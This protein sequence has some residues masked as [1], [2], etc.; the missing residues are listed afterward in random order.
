[1]DRARRKTRATGRSVHAA[2]RVAETVIT[3]GGFSVLAAVLAICLFLLAVVW[4]LFR[5]GELR[6]AIDAPAGVGDGLVVADEY[7]LMAMAVARDGS[8]SVRTQAEGRVVLEGSLA[9]GPGLTAL[10]RSPFSERVALG[11]ADGTVRLGRIGFASDRLGPDEVPAAAASL[12]RG[13]RVI[14]PV[15]VGGGERAGVVQRNEQGDYRFVRPV[16]ELEGAAA[17]AGEGAVV[18]VDHLLFNQREYVASVRAD[19]TAAVSQVRTIVPLG[20][21]DPIVRLREFPLDLTPDDAASAGLPSWLFVL[22]AG[23][24]VAAVWEDGRVRR[25]ARD[26]ADRYTPADTLELGGTITAAATLLGDRSLL[27]GLADGRVEQWFTAPDA[28]AAHADGRRLVRGSVF[29][30]G[31]GGEVT[32]LAISRRGRSVAIGRA[33]GGVVVRHFTSGQRVAGVSVGGRVDAVAFSPRADRL[34]ALTD[35]GERLLGWDLRPGYPEVT[36]GSMFWRTHYEGEPEPT[37][38]WQS[39]AAT[40]QSEPKLSLM[41]LIFGTTKATVF[42]MLFAVP[43]AVAGAVYTS[44]FLDTRL[45]RVVKPS[46][47]IMASLPSV[48]LGF[49]AAIVVAPFLR[50]WLATVLVGLFVVPVGV[51]VAAHLWQLLPQ[52]VVSRA[53]GGGLLGL[54]VLVASAGVGA[55]ALLG[56]AVER[57]LFTPTRGEA[58]LLA[59]SVRPAEP[60]QIPDWASGGGRLTEADE[61]RLAAM[62]LGVVGGEVVRPHEPAT[63]PER[64]RVQAAIER[65]RLDRA[66]VRRWLDGQFGGAYPGWFL[67]LTPVSLVAVAWGVGRIGGRRFYNLVARQGRTRAAVYELGRLVIVLSAS[68]GLAALGAWLLG[69]LGFDTR[70]WIFGNFV[71]RNTLV[72]GVIMGFAVIPIIYTISEDA[73]SSV[74]NGLRSASLG[75]GA[76]RWQTVRRVVMPVA[77]SGI[78]SACMIGLGRA[79]GETM[80]VLMAT[81]NTPTMDWNIFEGMRTLSANI[82]VELPEAAKGGTHYRVLFLCGLVLFAM[83]FVINTTAEVVRQYFRK[84]N[85]AL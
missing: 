2:D 3:L 21:G 34:L 6:R 40:D 68:I 54:L 61:R 66:S 20:G 85:A 17:V 52:R 47:E 11:L 75:A 79:V 78:F 30:G 35:G 26:E 5:G 37:F 73:L 41:P 36:L 14:A 55:S 39:S 51:V 56:P 18:L 76:T 69:G 10:A 48:V 19:G 83:T 63:G 62:G 27:L 45:R 32:A 44:E 16:L 58:L 28:A 49:V 72:V 84:R 43:L 13:G 82:A 42:A 65:A 50:D 31:D 24:T 57:A 70:S 81:G 12:E 74:P 8:V 25:F 23:D 77:A 71:Q 29:G 67:V 1:V 64:E 15:D 46:V 4:P 38:A 80:I 60:D 9:D 22:D 53:T 59:G 7:G 33:G